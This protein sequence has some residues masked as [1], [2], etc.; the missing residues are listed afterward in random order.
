MRLSSALS[1]SREKKPC[2]GKFDRRSIVVLP[3]RLMMQLATGSTRVMV[4]EEKLPSSV[5]TPARS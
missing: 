2:S 5:A 4:P 1:A 3:C